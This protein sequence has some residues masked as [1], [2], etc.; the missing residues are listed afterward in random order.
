MR[1]MNRATRAG[2]T[3]PM[4]FSWYVLPVEW[5]VS[6]LASMSTVTSDPVESTSHKRCSVSTGYS[7]PLQVH[8]G[9]NKRRYAR[10]SDIAGDSSHCARFVEGMAPGK[11]SRILKV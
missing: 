3:S 9:P 6:T 7:S 5:S 1:L 2:L 8:G 10:A 4:A 11:G